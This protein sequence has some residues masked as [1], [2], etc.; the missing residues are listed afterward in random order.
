[1]AI[2]TINIEC[3][4][5]GCMKNLLACYANCRY[6]GR[7]DDLRGEIV[8]RTE[9]A[10]NDINTFLVERSRRPIM[11]QILKRG[12]KFTESE[13]AIKKPEVKV[14]DRKRADK[15][16]APVKETNSRMDD[17]PVV[18]LLK[19]A[20]RRTARPKKIV[21]GVVASQKQPAAVVKVQKQ[22]AVFNLE[23]ERHS[24]MA[25]GSRR[26]EANSPP[27]IE[28][29]PRPGR[30]APERIIKVRSKTKRMPRR[31]NRPGAAG[32]NSQAQPAEG[33]AI[34]ADT[35][36]EKNGSRKPARRN[37]KNNGAKKATAAARGKLYII[38]EG[39]SASVVDE[40]GLMTHML[41]NHSTDARYFEAREVEARLQIVPKS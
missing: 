37:Q 10:T 14:I 11:I 7:C 39:K 33:Q 3:K 17:R 4:R 30:S 22:R 16:L 1:M 26:A 15:K 5:Y 38:L 24:Q 35:Q 27:P 9:Q 31:V 36:A 19:K 8:E 6:N 34:N 32:L 40:M 2:S 18:R 21:A 23:K 28:R 29:T 25:I 20:K 13:K 41:N 12:L